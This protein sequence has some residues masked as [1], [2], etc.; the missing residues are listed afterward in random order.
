MTAMKLLNLQNPLKHESRTLHLEILS[1]PLI[2]NWIS[3]LI[4]ILISV[5]MFEQMTWKFAC[6]TLSPAFGQITAEKTKMELLVP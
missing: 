3:L 4:L 1:I 6:R 2:L 5:W